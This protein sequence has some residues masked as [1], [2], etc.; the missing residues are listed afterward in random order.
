MYLQGLDYPLPISHYMR[1]IPLQ[2]KVINCGALG[3]EPIP[4]YQN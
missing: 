1:F 2:Y 4:D 3:S